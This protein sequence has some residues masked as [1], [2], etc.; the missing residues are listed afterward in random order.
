MT[1][2]LKPRTLLQKKNFKKQQKIQ[3]SAHL[4]HIFFFC[5]QTKSEKTFSTKFLENN[6][7]F[8]FFPYFPKQMTQRSKSR[9]RSLLASW[10]LQER[11]FV[12]FVQ[13]RRAKDFPASWDSSNYKLHN[14][15]QNW[16]KV[17]L[18]IITTVFI[19][20]LIKVKLYLH[21]C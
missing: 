2:T 13:R 4:F 18:E 6:I 11:S 12:L 8:F 20:W 7:S 5:G 3:E 19:L 10:I 16:I 14:R 1:E 21:L 9:R 17:N 15:N